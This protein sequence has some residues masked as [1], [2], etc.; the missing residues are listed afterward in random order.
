MTI[1]MARTET[2]D[3]LKSLYTRFPLKEAVKR[4]CLGRLRLP[5]E[6]WL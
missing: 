2:D 3:Q 4:G 6:R 5:V 1:V